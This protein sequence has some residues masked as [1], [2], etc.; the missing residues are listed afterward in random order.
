MAVRH[1]DLLCIATPGC[2]APL[3]ELDDDHGDI[4]LVCGDCGQQEHTGEPAVI[5]QLAELRERRAS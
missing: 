2:L 3:D 1:T 5:Y 4:T